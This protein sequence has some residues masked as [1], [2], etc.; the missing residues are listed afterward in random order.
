MNTSITLQ[1]EAV[2]IVKSSLELKRKA[3]ELNLRQYQARLAEYE[4]RFQM[5][6][7]QFDQKFGAGKLDDRA[8]W[9]EWEFVLDAQRETMKQLQLLESVKL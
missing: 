4:K 8:E 3:L 2:P 9:F 6:S 1:S 5:T 7:E